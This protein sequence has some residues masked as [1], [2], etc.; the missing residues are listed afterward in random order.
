VLLKRSRRSS[1]KE[2]QEK[3]Q[4]RGGMLSRRSRRSNVKEK[5]NVH[6]KRYQIGATLRRSAIEHQHQVVIVVTMQVTQVKTH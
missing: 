2:E 5:M 1:V 6:E 3:Q 4:R